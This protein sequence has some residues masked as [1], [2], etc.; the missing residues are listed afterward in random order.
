MDTVDASAG[1]GLLAGLLSVG[2]GYFSGLVVALAAITAGVAGARFVDRDRGHP[3]IARWGLG[4]GIASAGWA[5][6]LL[7]GVV[8]PALRGAILGGSLLPLWLLARRPRPFG[9][10]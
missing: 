9:G 6:F 10:G 4:F 3:G 1:F 2:A 8:P 5:G 7:P